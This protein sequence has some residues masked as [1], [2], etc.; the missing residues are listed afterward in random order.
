MDSV[1][2]CILSFFLC[3]V[4]TTT[5]FSHAQQVLT[6]YWELCGKVTIL[7]VTVSSRT[8]VL[9]AAVVVGTRLS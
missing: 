5:V 8:D 6:L 1:G 7:V 9:A 2:H 4:G 3:V